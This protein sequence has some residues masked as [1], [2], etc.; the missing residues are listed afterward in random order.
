[1]PMPAGGDIFD[2]AF[3]AVASAQ[4]KGSDRRKMA[5]CRNPDVSGFR[6]YR[7]RALPRR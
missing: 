6:M 2:P 5:F 7:N 1:M 3:A 4:F